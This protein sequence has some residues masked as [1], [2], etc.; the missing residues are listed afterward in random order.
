MGRRPRR[1]GSGRDRRAWPCLP[2]TPPVGLTPSPSPDRSPRLV[3]VGYL[4]RDAGPATATSG[5]GGA[6]AEP[7]RPVLDPGPP[8]PSPP[9]WSPRPKGDSPG[10]C[11]VSVALGRPAITH[12]DTEP[13][14]NASCAACGRPPGPCPSPT[15]LLRPRRPPT[16]SAHAGGRAPTAGPP[17]FPVRPRTTQGATVIDRDPRPT[18][19]AMRSR[20]SW[21]DRRRPQRPPGHDPDR[22]GGG[23]DRAPLADPEGML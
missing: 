8:A 22:G 10:T 3:E 19:A 12:R 5:A 6:A 23:R 7:M 1:D 18:S 13:L 21:A 16:T 14:T 17:R 4:V 2:S 11:P 9:S 20:E 15:R